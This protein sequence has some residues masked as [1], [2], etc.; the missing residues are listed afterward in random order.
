MGGAWSRYLLCSPPF[1]YGKRISSATPSRFLALRME[2]ERSSIVHSRRLR[3]QNSSTRSLDQPSRR[4][5]STFSSEFKQRNRNPL[6]GS[7]SRSIHDV[8]FLLREKLRLEH[9]LAKAEKLLEV[10][11]SSSQHLKAEYVSIVYWFT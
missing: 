3:R 11:R 2:D 10:Q 9:E 8:E 5:Q 1:G 6:S 7:I 4:I